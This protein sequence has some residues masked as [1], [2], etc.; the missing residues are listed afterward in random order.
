[1]VLIF[2]ILLTLGSPLGICKL[3]TKGRRA[4][5]TSSHIQLC[6]GCCCLGDLC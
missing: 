1:M 5:G 2:L 6:P 3:R 4:R